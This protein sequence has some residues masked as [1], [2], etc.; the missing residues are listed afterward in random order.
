MICG[1]YVCGV[2]W[3]YTQ[4]MCGRLSVK[5]EGD[6]GQ[7][8]GSEE[9]SRGQTEWVCLIIVSC[10]LKFDLYNVF[11]CKWQLLLFA[12]CIL[13]FC[14]HC[15]I[16]TVVICVLIFAVH[17]RFIYY[18]KPESATEILSV[19]L[20]IGLTLRVPRHNLGMSQTFSLPGNSRVVIL[21][22]GQMTIIFVVSVCLSVSLFVQSFSQPSLIRFRSN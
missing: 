7:V 20:F 16:C 15:N 8:S 1:V 11:I 14:H 19:S 5:V 17:C 10:L 4:E 13:M 6:G 12:F 2:E 22:H 9:T 18:C 3:G 21:V